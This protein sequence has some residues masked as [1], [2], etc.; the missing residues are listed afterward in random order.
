MA[1]PVLEPAASTAPARAELTG[2]AT[3]RQA[4]AL[5]LRTGSTVIPRPGLA[6]LV[7]L[8]IFAVV[9]SSFSSHY[10]VD[11]AFISLRYARNLAQGHGLVYST[12]GS[13]RVEGY[14][15]FLWVVME[16][17]LFRMGLER[18]ILP[19]L[20]GVGIGFGLLFLLACYAVAKRLFDSAD[21]GLA[22]VFLI[23]C[24]GYFAFWSVGGLETPLYLFLL[25]AALYCCLRMEEWRF[26]ALAAACFVAAAL[27]RPEAAALFAGIAAV[28]LAARVWGKSEVRSSRWIL[29][30]AIFAAVYGT[31]F[32]LRWHY[33]GY[34]L[35]NTFYAKTGGAAG[36]GSALRHVA[37]RGAASATFFLLIVPFSGILAAA[38]PLRLFLTRFRIAWLF[39]IGLLGLSFLAREEWMPGFRYELPAGALFAILLAY[40]LAEYLR[41]HGRGVAV[42]TSCGLM[43]FLAY[44]CAVTYTAS[45]HEFGNLRRAHIA[46]GEWLRDATP[47]AI[48]VAGWDQGAIPYYSEKSR[49]IEIDPEG[50]LSNYLTHHPFSNDYV[51]EQ[52]PD[53]LLLPSG[54]LN[55][56]PP[57]PPGGT[58]TMDSL[59]Y[60][61]RLATNYDF[62][63]A[64]AYD[65]AYFVRVYKRRDLAVS[66][67]KIAHLQALAQ[68]SVVELNRN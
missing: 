48:S 57:P 10:T 26:T 3:P 20:K 54:A 35:P 21:A 45:R 9:A 56:L 61:A 65:P 39:A 16:A 2:G 46:L 23:V 15:N 42:A 29:A 67:E 43:V 28:E 11:D 30:A 32:V 6:L 60:D 19:V 17:G 34:F 38:Y 7:L 40:P 55:L 47:P 24:S 51:F 27:T 25:I 50:L 22:A 8:G 49:I 14:T 41:R 18:E 44:P 63:A 59:Y 1:N 64:F 37:G 4:A 52:K 53:I 58:Q 13:E 31:Y 5:P 12:D 33:Y 66:A 62:L 36:M 68:R